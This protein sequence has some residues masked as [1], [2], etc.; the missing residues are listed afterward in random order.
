MG[1]YAYKRANTRYRRKF[2]RNDDEGQLMKQ[3]YEVYTI[4]ECGITKEILDSIKVG[5]LIKCNDWKQ[6]LTVKAVSE[7]YF[8]MTRNAFGKPLYSIC[9]KK[10]SN[11]TRN[12]YTKGAFRIGTDNLIF[13]KYDYLKQEDCEKAIRDFEIG[14]TELSVRRAVDLKLIQ[15]KKRDKN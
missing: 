7:N 10:P 12:F 9:E 15:I 8:I 5:D 3:Q 2:A 14:K 13:G 4:D 6:P 11:G 1:H